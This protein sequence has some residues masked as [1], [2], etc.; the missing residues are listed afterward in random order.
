MARMLRI[1]AAALLACGA[2]VGPAQAQ[3]Q[4]AVQLAP[5]QA[6]HT[7]PFE[8]YDGR[9]YI[10]ASIAGSGPRTFLVDTGAQI[11]HLTSE[12]VNELGLQTGGSIGITGVGPGRIDGQY[13][14]GALLD[15]GGVRL[16]TK[17]AIAAPGE[18]LFGP[19]YAGSG[20]RFEGVI[21]YDL[22]AAYAVEVDYEG[23]A[24]RLYDPRGYRLPE[25]AE[26]VPIRLVDK[27]PYLTGIVSLGGRS[28]EANLHFDTGSGGAIG[29]NGNFVEGEGL[30]A[31]AGTTLPSYNRGV[32]GITAA[33]LGR[34][35]SLTIG[36]TVVEQPFVTLA[37]A[38]GR[39]V[40]SDSAGR[41]GGAI[42]RRFTV[43]INYAGRTVGLLPNGNFGLP[44]ETDMSGLALAT[45]A[46]GVV[47]VLRVEEASAGAE[48]GIR[49]G[50][51]LLSIDG[52]SAPE[53]S[54]EA[55]RGMLMQHGETRL[56][57]VQRDGREL[58]LPIT[59]RR[60]I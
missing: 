34:A 46:D 38:Q 30:L 52:R 25:G 9:I 51:R 14:R 22:F 45:A 60:R 44:I 35:E 48:A 11:T 21:G 7:L 57:V 16:P 55:I 27:K 33:R 18:A 24:L 15:M 41:I 23:R 4:P 31:L 56:L 1:F 20:K 58:S 19:V 49:A 53:L 28:I 42:L 6:L 59:L 13:V 29:F 47:Q 17:K 39:G 12:L 37:L 36:K 10:Q 50:D 32:G 2:L 40:R 5:S 26:I 3:V 54:L 8:L 43:A